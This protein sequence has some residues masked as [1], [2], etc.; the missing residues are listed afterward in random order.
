MDAWQMVAVIYRLRNEKLHANKILDTIL[1]YDRLNHLAR[2][3]KYVWQNSPENKQQFIGFIKN[4][5]PQQTFLELAT[6]YYNIGRKEEAEKVLQLSKPNAEI[7]YWLSFLQNKSLPGKDLN[8]EL[9]FPFRP[10]TVEVLENLIQK[11]DN[12]LLKYHLALIQWNFNNISAA[13]DLF[14]QCGNQPVYAPFY[15]ARANFNMNNDSLKVLADLQQAAKLDKD[16]WRYGKALINYYLKQNQS[17]TASAIAAQYYKQFPEN[18]IIGMLNAKALLMNKQYSAANKILQAI[19][20]LPNEGATDGRQL[21]REVQLMLA[22][23]EMKNKN[24][25]KA[26]N[27]TSAARLWPDDL[28]VGKPYDSDIDERLEDWLTYQCY[29]KLKNEKNAQQMLNKILSFSYSDGK[30]N[31]SSSA[32][33]LITAWAMQKAGKQEQAEKFL[34]DWNNKAPGNIW[35]QWAVNTYKGKKFNLP[36]EML[37]NE[38]YRILQQWFDMQ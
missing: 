12:W 32:N 20:I 29:I 28:G 8:P 34:Q 38:N 13:K 37:A 18:Y 2:F 5:M 17:D 14:D 23:E 1:L 11:N 27:Y 7:L 10:E 6:W 16:Q 9:V 3:E 33:N 24:C 21:Y 25:E 35:A 15:A 36:D 22:I 4:E 26:L 31:I 30:G 19:K